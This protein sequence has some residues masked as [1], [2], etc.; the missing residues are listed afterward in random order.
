MG[1]DALLAVVPPADRALA[2]AAL[3]QLAAAPPE[4]G[5]HSRRMITIARRL[6]L[7]ESTDVA[8]LLIACCVHDLGLLPAARR[9]PGRSFPERS[10]ALLDELATAYDVAPDRA[11]V[12]R[13]AIRDHLRPRGGPQEGPEAALLRRAAWLDATRIGTAADR[14]AMRSLAL[15]RRLGASVRLLARVGGTLVRDRLT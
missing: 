14:R 5:A 6:V 12:W 15:D 4:I 3:A 13:T 2:L 8:M 11:E 10:A 1:D 9:L 7:P